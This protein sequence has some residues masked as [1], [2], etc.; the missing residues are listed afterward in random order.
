[1]P[2]MRKTMPG[3]VKIRRIARAFSLEDKGAM[4]VLLGVMLLPTLGL[5][6]ATVDYARAS[7]AKTALQASL[8]AAALGSLGGKASSP[9]AIRAQAI[10]ATS[11]AKYGNLAG[12]TMTT[13]AVGLNRMDATATATIKHQ[14]PLFKSQTIVTASSRAVRGAETTGTFTIDA[15]FV[16]SDAW[17][18]N[19]AFIYRMKA[20]DK[21]ILEKK[22]IASN[23]STSPKN[24]EIN[25]GVGEAYGFML[26]NTK[27]G[28]INYNSSQCG[29]VTEWYSHNK[30]TNMRVSNPACEKPTTTHE[31]EDTPGGDMDFNDMVY[32][33]NCIGTPPTGGGNSFVRLER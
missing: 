16:F 30:P 31:W 27:C 23:T 17:D 11:A 2:L 6:G 7:S 1:M 21:T 13:A 24:V 4:G 26:K 14:I 32:E 15:R 12:A 29:K 22:L 33:F 3:L 9:D 20:D 10:F 18:K 8:D 25:L 19:E 5:A 28:R